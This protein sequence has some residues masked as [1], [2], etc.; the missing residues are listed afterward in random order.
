MKTSSI[1]ASL[2]LALAGVLL[3]ACAPRTAPAPAYHVEPATPK[4]AATPVVVETATPTATAV[5]ESTPAPPVHSGIELPA[6]SSWW[7]RVPDENRPDAE[8]LALLLHPRGEG[9][10]VLRRVSRKQPVD[11]TLHWLQSTFRSFEVQDQIESGSGVPHEEVTFAGWSGQK[12]IAGLAGVYVSDG[13]AYAVVATCDRHFFDKH[14]ADFDKV[15][16]EFRPEAK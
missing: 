2:G 12:A 16:A 3:G 11:D 10:L 15:L 4:A 8:T 1:L 7:I 9:R 13:S 5:A 14:K 6:P